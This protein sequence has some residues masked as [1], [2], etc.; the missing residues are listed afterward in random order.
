MNDRVVQLDVGA[1]VCC[2]SVRG[3]ERVPAQPCSTSL[4][5]RVLPQKTNET[6]SWV[7]NL[8]SEA[9]AFHRGASS[10]SHCSL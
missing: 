1:S 8:L 7:N 6:V 4:I 9:A 3:K 10:R 2:G 5:E